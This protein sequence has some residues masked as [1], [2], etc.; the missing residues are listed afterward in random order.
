M[1][2]VWLAPMVDGSEL[3]FRMMCRKY[4]ATVAYTPMLRAHEILRQ[5]CCDDVTKSTEEIAVIPFP[6][7]PPEDQ[8]LVVQLCGNDPSELANAATQLLSHY[9]GTLMGIDLNL[10]CPQE[11]AEKENIG[12]F[13]AENEPERACQCIA[14]LKEAVNG[15]CR[16]SC[17]IRLVSNSSK[18]NGGNSDGDGDGNSD[19]DEDGEDDDDVSAATIQFAQRLVAAGVELIAVHVRRREDKHN[20][21][22]D[23]LTAQALVE[24]LD[25][26]VVINGGISTREQALHVLN[27]TRC[28]AV[29]VAQGFLTNPRMLME[30]KKEFNAEQCASMAAE[31]LDFCE[32]YRPPTPYYIRKHL[33]WIFRSLLQGPS[34]DAPKKWRR[35]WEKEQWR[36]QMWHYISRSYLTSLWQFR[37]VV[38]LFCLLSFVSEEEQIPVSVASLEKPSFH[39]IRFRKGKEHKK[40]KDAPYSHQHLN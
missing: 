6:S 3:A 33:R 9:D 22:P 28:H 29:M 11:I 1:S 39:S 35:Q 17:K 23:L 4:G 16:V 24:A 21:P 40:R 15:R 20:G 12:A 38:H 27:V 10:G 34:S 18:G 25:I 30:E 19:G 36:N 7:R 31:Y 32:K 26:P 5:F 14:A 37:Q 8:P 13:L 2:Q